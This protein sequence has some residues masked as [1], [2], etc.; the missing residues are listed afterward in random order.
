MLRG[1]KNHKIVSSILAVATILLPMT[2]CQKENI[3]R[4][5]AVSFHVTSGN[6]DTKAA[7]SG[8]VVD[9]YERID[10]VE[11]D[12]IRI[13]CDQASYGKPGNPP[14]IA[15]ENKFADYKV[16]EGITA[17]Q[18]ISEATIKKNDANNELLWGNEETDHY[19]YAVYPSPATS[20]PWV[21][22]MNKNTITGTVKAAQTGDGR[23]SDGMVMVA[24]TGPLRPGTFDKD[25]VF[26]EFSPITTAIKFSITNG[27]TINFTVTKVELKSASHPLSGTFSYNIGEGKVQDT[28]ITDAEKEVSITKN[29]LL[30]ADKANTYEFT[31]LLRPD[32]DLNDLSLVITTGSGT[33]TSP[34]QNGSGAYTFTQGSKTVIT[35]VVLEKF[36]TLTGFA[37]F[38]AVDLR[39]DGKVEEE[40]L[41]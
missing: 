18:K 36:L 20:S 3:S 8:T 33:Y 13:W 37:S 1:M 19:F 17:N 30:S 26:L 22:A 24:K 25:A 16:V 41:F 10:W 38:T 29:Q 12:L 6:H 21:S 27:Q 32:D 11:N 15:N 23:F 31:F 7:Y 14:V 4:G 2:G 35:G 9:G 34:L 28:S 5:K 39:N 40:I